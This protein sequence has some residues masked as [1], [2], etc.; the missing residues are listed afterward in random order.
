MRTAALVA[1]LLAALVPLTATAAPAAK[2]EAKVKA[3]SAAEARHTSLLA[4]A[5]R[6][7]PEAQ[8]H[9]GLAY[10]DGGHGIKA[11]APAALVWFTL[12]GAD[13]SAP[14]AVEA[15]KA[16]EAGRGTKR[17]LNAAG[18]WWYRA[19]VLGD[20]AARERW[21]ALFMEGSV[22]SIGGRNGVEWLSEIAGQGNRKAIMALGEAL[23][24]GTGIAPDELAAEGWYRLA[25]LLYSDFE[26]RYRLG[27]MMLARSAMWRVP[28]DEEWNAKDAERKGHS[29]GAVWYPAKPGNA[30]DR[31]V[32]LRPGIVEGEFW[33]R[34]AARHGHAEAQYAL[35]SILVAGFELPLDM[36]EGISWLEAAAVQGHAE[37]MMLLGGL[38]AKGQGF[39]GKDPV[40]AFVMF[41]L[42]AAQGEEGAAA[43]RD[44]VAKTLNQRQGARARQLVQDLR[45][46]GSGQ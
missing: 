37:A 11:D 40:R 43:A 21:A 31:A 4:A 33:L 15:A 7:E 22:H 38:A 17:D 1:A 19:G 29:F 34:S 3:P 10:R 46:L 12:A 26:A 5:L 25:A 2:A 6:G 30:E 35:G 16:F 24:R 44:S 45:E 28:A 14:A 42:A 23:E 13:G 41:D 8:Y 20:Q 32:Q 18:N 27:R 36:V 39:Y 9:L